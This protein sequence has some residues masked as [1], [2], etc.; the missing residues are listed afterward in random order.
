MW[1]FCGSSLTLK[2]PLE[3]SLHSYALGASWV[4]AFCIRRS[5]PMLKPLARAPLHDVAGMLKLKR[6][7]TGLG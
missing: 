2:V 6:S 5:R 7:V 3:G 4:L 1:G